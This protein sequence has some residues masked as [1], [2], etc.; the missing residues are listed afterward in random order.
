MTKIT[1]QQKSLLHLIVRTRDIGDGWRQV[2]DTLWGVVSANAV[3]ELMELDV[4]LKRVRLS[5]EGII[6]MG[7]M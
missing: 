6:V 2:S 1:D 3:P 4:E 7:W 5:P